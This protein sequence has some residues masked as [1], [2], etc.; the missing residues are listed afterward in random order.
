M[1]QSNRSPQ[2]KRKKLPT[3]FIG[4]STEAH[5]VAEALQYLVDDVCNADLWSYSF[6]LS[7]HTLETL[8]DSVSNYD[9]AVLIMNPDDRR[10]SRDV[11]TDVPRD[12]VIFELGLFVGALGR[13]RTFIVKQA[14]AE[15][16]TD[17]RGIM[18]MDIDWDEG[19]SIV[20]A[21]SSKCILLK[22]AIRS[23]GKRD[24]RSSN[25]SFAR[26]LDE[27]GIGVRTRYAGPFPHC[28]EEI[29]KLL[30][31][32]ERSIQILCDFPCYGFFSQRQMYIEYEQILKDRRLDDVKIE[33]VFPNADLRLQLQEIQF[34]NDDKAPWKKRYEEDHSFRRSVD[35]AN[36]MDNAGI[37]SMESLHKYLAKSHDD[38][39]LSAPEF[40]NFKGCINFTPDMPALY[41]WIVDD[42]RAIFTIPMFGRNADEHGFYT[43]ESDV[44]ESLNSIWNHYH[45]DYGPNFRRGGQPPAPGQ[46]PVKTS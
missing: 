41:A 29:C 31:S 34:E 17:L 45:P 26:L 5:P 43:S 30:R 21:V 19:R 11:A 2:G 6:P 27:I 42:V 24:V 9:F 22:E 39:L 28:F 4:S 13:N 12:N 15:L 44:V 36:R 37:D 20:S 10:V 25:N 32:A 38:R 14:G 40:K 35:V 23:L 33:F 3:L 16:P 18:T 7:K 8:V 1:K 46:A